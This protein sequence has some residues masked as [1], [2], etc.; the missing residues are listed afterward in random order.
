ME[1]FMK[2]AWMLTI[3]VFSSVCSAAVG[4]EKERRKG[5]GNSFVYLGNTSGV[6][7]S[8]VIHK[9]LDETEGVVCYVYAPKNIGLKNR[10]GAGHCTEMADGDIGSISCLKL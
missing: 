5:E 4:D 2:A 6:F 7:D 1:F 8:T 3:L 10:C 9:L